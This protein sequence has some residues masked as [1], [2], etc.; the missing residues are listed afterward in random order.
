MQVEHM[1]M[2]RIFYEKTGRAK[3]IAHLDLMRLMTRALRRSRL[4]LW[5]T[6]GFN[7]HLYLTFPLP[8]ALGYEGLR[9][10]FDLRLTGAVPYPE[11]GDRLNAAL[12][13]GLRVLEAA[14]PERSPA[15]IA[16][17]DYAVTLRYRDAA[18]P[19][20]EEKLDAFLRQPVI[21]VQKR[22]K[23]G[24]LTVDIKPQFQA[25]AREAGP[26][27]LALRLRMAAGIHGSIA[28]TLLLKAFYAWSGVFP[29]GVKVVREAV[30]CGDFE[31]FR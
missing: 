27:R 1:P 17:A 16:W 10:S 28:P 7:P 30:L 3:Y 6:Q 22:S 21:E 4:P 12:P 20:L 25:L 18:L 15:D 13:P 5:Y 8:L 31:V 19:A 11:V 2:A 14:P 23:K 29:D 26:E 24:E 9:E